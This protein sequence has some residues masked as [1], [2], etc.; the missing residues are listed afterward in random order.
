MG[1]SENT[2][3][4][5][6]EQ[7]TPG[8]STNVNPKSPK[9]DIYS[10]ARVRSPFSRQIDT[11]MAMHDGSGMSGNS[12]PGISIAQGTITSYL[13]LNPGDTLWID[14]W[15]PCRSGTLFGACI[16]LVILGIGHRWLAAVRACVGRMIHDEVCVSSSLLFLRPR[17]LIR[18]VC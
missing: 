15:V 5:Q 12:M 16:A 1:H 17:S 11:T 8:R 13:H 4:V 18:S 2:P 14:G 10:H 7:T 9:Q 6:R 3:A